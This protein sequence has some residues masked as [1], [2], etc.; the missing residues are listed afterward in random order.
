MTTLRCGSPYCDHIGHW[1]H[2]RGKRVLDSDTLIEAAAQL[3][4]VSNARGVQAVNVALSRITPDVLNIM[5]P[6]QKELDSLYCQRIMVSHGTVNTLEESAFFLDL[7]L[8]PGKIVVIDALWDL[9]ARVKV[10]MIVLNA[11]YVRTRL[12]SLFEFDA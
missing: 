4:N 10:A 7:T 1:R 12:R 2:D 5:R 6:V 3:W 8:R 11:E 9:D